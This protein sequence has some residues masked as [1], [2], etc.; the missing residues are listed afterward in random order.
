M[1]AEPVVVSATINLNTQVVLGN[2]EV[3]SLNTCLHL[4]HTLG[5]DFLQPV[6][7]LVLEGIFKSLA[8]L[9]LAVK[10]VKFTHLILNFLETNELGE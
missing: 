5:I 7:D 6:D 4:L 10:T 8:I 2:V 9:E 3:N 1:L